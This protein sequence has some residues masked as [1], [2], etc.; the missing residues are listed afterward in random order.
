MG[1]LQ[2]PGNPRVVYLA[3]LL[4][5]HRRQTMLGRL[6]ALHEH[7]ARL[8]REVFCD[9]R[10]GSYRY[11]NV[12]DGGLRD[13]SVEDETF[14]YRVMPVECREDAFRFALWR[15]TDGRYR[16]AVEQYYDR[17][18]RALNHVDPGHTLPARI[19]RPAAR[20]LRVR[21][22]SA[23]DVERWA[24]LLRRASALT[25]RHPEIKGSW[26]DCTAEQRQSV[27]VNSEGTEVVGQHEVCGLSLFLQRYTARGEPVEQE[28]TLLTGDPAELPSDREVMGLVRERIA[29]LN[30]LAEAPWLNSYSG[31]VLLSPRAAGLFFHEVVGH[32]LEGSRLLS[33]EE[34]STFQDLQGRDLAPRFLSIVDDPTLRR[35]R[36]RSLLGHFR[37]DDE[38][39][40]ARRVVL[41]DHGVLRRFL[42]T[43][44]PIPGQ[45]ELNGHARSAFHERPISRMGNL[46]VQ[47]HEPVPAAA[48]RERFL[49]EIRRQKKAFGIHVKETL[50][51]ET[52]TGSY[53]FQ[54]FKGEILHAVRVFPD[55][56]EEPV[57]GVDFVGTPLS[58]LDALTALGDD[59]EVDNAFCTAESGS[60]P[61]S[62]IAP[63][64]LLRTLELQ[65][66]ERERYT[67]FVLPL[68]W[69]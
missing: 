46:L 12:T 35:F 29:R 50:G 61:V 48:L 16:E 4:R 42:T 28:V 13:N 8:Y 41:V 33:P 53:D 49:E 7:S 40:P 14:E 45:R 39:S 11:D 9:L 60:V 68:P 17:K 27:L 54:A 25:R 64:A 58:A 55:G 69:E 30:A 21:P 10:V 32:R 66:K 1:H 2:R 15:L 51:G 23:V 62:T 19:K 31:P 22:F 3:Y 56:R 44:A 57:R 43:A 38:G 20:S 18:A 63:S 67:P 37:Y 52:Q 59:L 65:A 6:G 47:A 26:I 36:G 5:D 34:G 24:N